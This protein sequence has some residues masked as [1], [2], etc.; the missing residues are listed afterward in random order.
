MS[1][2]TVHVIPKLFCRWCHKSRKFGSSAAAGVEVWEVLQTVLTATAALLPIV[3][4]IRMGVVEATYGYLGWSS[5][6]FVVR[7]DF[8]TLNPSIM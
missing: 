4:P 1:A 6:W 3:G 8:E 5:R 2:A 7:T